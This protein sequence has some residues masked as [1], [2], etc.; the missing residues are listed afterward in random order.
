MKYIKRFEHVGSSNL[1][2]E[3][4]K[5]VRSDNFKSWFG[6]WENDPINSS[7]VLDSNGE[8][9]VVYHSSISNDFTEFRPHITKY[10]GNSKWKEYYKGVDIPDD[11]WGNFVSDVQD[12]D[13]VSVYD[14]YWFSS[15]PWGSVDDGGGVV[16]PFFLNIRNIKIGDNGGQG[17][18]GTYYDY[19]HRHDKQD[20]LIIPNAEGSNMD[21]YITIISNNIKI[22]N[23]NN[24]TFSSDKNFYN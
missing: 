23:G 2:P 5:I 14:E 19:I 10:E 21:Y 9:L 1:S 17:G 11:E 8:P 18:Q 24:K 3:L 13:G 7:K 22:A 20:G 15:K 12:T 6:D 4:Q 16:I